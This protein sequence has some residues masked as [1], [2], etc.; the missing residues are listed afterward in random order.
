[1]SI[2]LVQGLAEAI[3]TRDALRII[4]RQGVE[5]RAKKR[6]LAEW[7]QVHTRA[8]PD[9]GQKKAAYD[10]LLGRLRNARLRG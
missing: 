1:M 3:R 7:F 9:P 5:D 6:L 10:D 2:F 8:A 4:K